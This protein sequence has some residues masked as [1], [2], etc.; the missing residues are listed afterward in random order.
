MNVLNSLLNIY[1][2]GKKSLPIDV[3]T[4]VHEQNWTKH[5]NIFGTEYP[6]AQ[7]VRNFSGSFIITYRILMALENITWI[8]TVCISMA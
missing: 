3:R 4:D 8:R 1:E 2:C 6:N 7:V 5:L